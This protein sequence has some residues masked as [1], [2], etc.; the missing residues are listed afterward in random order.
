MYYT[1][2]D[3][4][5]SSARTLELASSGIFHESCYQAAY[6]NLGR[7]LVFGKRCSERLVGLISSNVDQSG[8][9]VR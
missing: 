9:E 7:T 4:L 3:N 8:A 2:S 5:C 1:T 6:S